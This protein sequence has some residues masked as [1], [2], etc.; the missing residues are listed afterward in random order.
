MSLIS[1]IIKYKKV[2]K[3]L[4][5]Y[6]FLKLSFSTHRIRHSTLFGKKIMITDPFWYVHSLTEIFVDETYKFEPENS[7]PL[8]I[9]CGSN[10]GLSIIYFKKYYS[11]ARVIGF[12][13]DIDIAN[14]AKFNLNK[15]GIEDVELNAKAVWINDNPLFFAKKGSLSGHIVSEEA[16]NTIKVETVRLKHY[17]NQSVDFL[18]IDI[19]GSEYDIIVDC[20]DEL[21][22]IKNLFIE[23][24]SFGDNPQMI[25]ELLIILKN[26]GFK[27]Y[28][29]E[30]WKNMKNPFVQRKG[31]Y[32]DLQL[33]IFAYRK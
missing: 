12:E 25:G 22:N 26:A 15:M 17:L 9:D 29:K 13:A 21:K 24:H 20:K 6:E 28:I 14:M 7:Q 32:F 5:F 8:I 3:M 30:A 16:A 1:K 10:I 2:K 18:K 23:Y 19:E 31:P 4:S 11:S 27:V 33:N